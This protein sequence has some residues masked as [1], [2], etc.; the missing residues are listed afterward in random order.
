MCSSSLTSHHL[1]VP[2]NRTDI[3]H[4]PPRK[5]ERS[6]VNIDYTSLNQGDTNNILPD[7]HAYNAM[8]EG[9]STRKFSADRFKRMKG[10]EL[11]KAWAEQTGCVEP[12][13][14]PKD[15]NE[16]LEMTMPEDLTVR[17]VA[18]LVGKD[19]KVEVIGISL[20][21]GINIDVPSQEVVKES[22]KLGKWADYYD[23]PGDERDRVRNV[24]YF[25]SNSLMT[26]VHSKS[27]LQR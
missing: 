20:V 3:V 9:D 5:S 13:V 11:T 16:G 25:P 2:S 15:M 14:I 26:I 22:W 7:Q 4:P 10:S 8:F 17:K 21:K 27:R 18:E 12:V 6:H 24:M 23:T 19:A 1:Y